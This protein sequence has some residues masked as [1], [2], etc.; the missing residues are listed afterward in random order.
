MMLLM[1]MFTTIML[2]PQYS[3]T[4]PHFSFSLL[5]LTMSNTD[6]SAKT[7]DL[8][9]ENKNLQAV[10]IKKGIFVSADYGIMR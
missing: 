8:K 1:M 5:V 9:F 2:Q 3:G 10:G 4:L 7:K 6:A